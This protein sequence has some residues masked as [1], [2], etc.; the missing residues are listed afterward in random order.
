MG[1]GAAATLAPCTELCAG[2]RDTRLEVRAGK[3]PRSVALGERAPL[4]HP[5]PSPDHAVTHS[6]VI[7]LGAPP[8]CSH[9]P[10]F[11]MI[12][13]VWWRWNLSHRGRLHR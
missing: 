12:I 8:R 10:C 11:V 9:L 6:V 7:H 4:P 1:G 13:S 5:R 3:R 2:R